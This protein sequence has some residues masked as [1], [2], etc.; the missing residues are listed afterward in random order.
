MVVFL[1]CRYTEHQELYVAW[2]NTRFMKIGHIRYGIAREKYSPAIVDKS[3]CETQNTPVIRQQVT[4]IYRILLRL[5]S[6]PWVRCSWY[7]NRPFPQIVNSNNRR[8]AT[9]FKTV[10]TSILLRPP[11]SIT[12]T[13]PPRAERHC[14]HRVCVSGTR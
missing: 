13:F 11:S 6:F 4:T 12:Q 8:R 1:Y 3:S 7:R 14:D 5:F 2:G 9:T 10:L